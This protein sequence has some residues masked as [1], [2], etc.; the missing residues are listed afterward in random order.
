[1]AKVHRYHHHLKI[2]TTQNPITK[3]HHL[4][5]TEEEE[6]VEVAE[7]LIKVM[8]LCVQVLGTALWHISLSLQTVQELL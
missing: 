4:Q 7:S 1:M 5:K 8:F 3:L 2:S 6:G